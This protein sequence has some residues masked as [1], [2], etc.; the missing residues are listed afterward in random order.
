[1]TNPGQPE[2]MRRSALSESEHYINDIKFATW[3]AYETEEL[4]SGLLHQLVSEMENVYW[5]AY[6]L[7]REHGEKISTAE[8]IEIIVTQEETAQ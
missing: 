7:G 1:M 8:A 6:R 2:K 3:N 5:K 4:P